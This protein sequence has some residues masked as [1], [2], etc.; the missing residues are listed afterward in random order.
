MLKNVTMRTMLSI[1][2]YFSFKMVLSSAGHD[3]Y[4]CGQGQDKPC[5]TFDWLLGRFYNISFPVKNEL[6][7]I[8]DCD[9]TVNKEIKVSTISINISI[10]L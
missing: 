10:T 7:L 2:G 5:A 9:F 4:D 6:E 3:N 1:F 8:T